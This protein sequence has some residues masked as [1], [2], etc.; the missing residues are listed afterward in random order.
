MSIP[1]E[2]P[3]CKAKLQS[4]VDIC[5]SVGR[6][7]SLGVWCKSC[8]I[9]YFHS[10]KDWKCTLPS[11]KRNREELCLGYLDKDYVC[12]CGTKTAE[13]ITV[14]QNDK[15]QIIVY[16]GEKTVFPNDKNKR[17][18]YGGEKKVF[19]KELFMTPYRQHLR[20]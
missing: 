9:G 4:H 13:E 12:K 5:L 7:H 19:P 8:K 15:N 10:L 1:T 14:F 17:I 6:Y 11:L 2:C 18:V 3:K 20:E 16:D